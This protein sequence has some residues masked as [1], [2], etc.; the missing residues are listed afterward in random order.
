M[1]YIKFKVAGEIDKEND[2]YLDVELMRLQNMGHYTMY[3]IG[4]SIFDIIC[5]LDFRKRFTIPKCGCSDYIVVRF[6][7]KTPNRGIIPKDIFLGE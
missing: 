2:N 3:S 6:K 4:Q 7:F 5:K 1:D